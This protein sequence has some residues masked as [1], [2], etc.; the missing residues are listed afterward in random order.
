MFLFKSNI[1]IRTRLKGYIGTPRKAIKNSTR[2]SK[3]QVFSSRVPKKPKR[4]R[5]GAPGALWDLLTSILLQNIKKLKGNPLESLKNC[6]NKI[7]QRQKKSKRGYRSRLVFS[8]VVES[9]T[10]NSLALQA[11]KQI[12]NLPSI[13]IN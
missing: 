1:Q 6:Q 8:F 5:T 4:D 13:K 9:A 12:L 3:C 11:L 10:R 7:S 2:T